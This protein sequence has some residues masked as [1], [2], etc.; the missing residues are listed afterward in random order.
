M[1]IRKNPILGFANDQLQPVTVFVMSHGSHSRELGQYDDG[2]EDA[3][4]L[5]KK[6]NNAFN[7]Q[8]EDF[9]G[10]A[11]EFYILVHFVVIVAVITT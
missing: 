1:K 3:T 2:D 8:K 11:R 9:A 6:A 5:K 4:K 10:P 7:E